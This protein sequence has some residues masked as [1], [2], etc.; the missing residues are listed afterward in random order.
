MHIM[1]RQKIKAFKSRKRYFKEIWL[2]DSLYHR[3]KGPAVNNQHSLFYFIEG[4]QYFFN[5]DYFFAVLND[6]FPTVVYPNGT[7]EWLDSKG[8]ASRK[9]EP[10]IEYSNGDKE[11]WLN[12]ER[13]RDDGPAV[14][15]GKKKYWFENG[16]FIKMEIG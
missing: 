8:F 14:I 11:W 3:K 12:G 5:G 1:I 4:K 13:H 16:I 7:K 6:E 10:S 2:K 15:H 9:T